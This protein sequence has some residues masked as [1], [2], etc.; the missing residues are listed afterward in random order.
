[1]ITNEE[2]E[3]YIDTDH[4][5]SLA[6]KA[7]TQLL[8]KNSMKYRGCLKSARKALLSDMI[9]KGCYEDMKKTQ[10]FISYNYTQLE[11]L[12]DSLAPL[13]VHKRLR[14]Y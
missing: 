6:F 13:Q 12:G 11:I 3:A 14:S 5:T 2:M 10:D 7:L 8:A 9:T 1:M 4:D